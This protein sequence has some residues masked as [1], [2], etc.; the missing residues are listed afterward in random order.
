MR[1]ICLY[2]MKTE[3]CEERFELNNGLKELQAEDAERKD[4]C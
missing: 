1:F 4:S 2:R 3:V